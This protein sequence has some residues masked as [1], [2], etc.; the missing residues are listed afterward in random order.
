LKAF[1]L[2]IWLISLYRHSHSAKRYVQ[3]YRP[4]LKGSFIMADFEFDFA[5]GDTTDQVDT[6]WKSEHLCTPGCITGVLMGCAFKSIT[7]NVTISR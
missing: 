5:A 2:N 3:H 7:C 6:Q 4:S 1:E